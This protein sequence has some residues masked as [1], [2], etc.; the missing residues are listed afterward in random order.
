[1]FNGKALNIVLFTLLVTLL[2]AIPLAV[3]K[4]YELLMWVYS[5]ITLVF[6]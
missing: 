1:M 2:V 5:Q 3:W 4:M 6:R